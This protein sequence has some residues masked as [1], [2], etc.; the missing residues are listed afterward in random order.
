MEMDLVLSNW[1]IKFRSRTTKITA[2][3]GKNPSN[4]L[5]NKRIVE[6]LLPIDLKLFRLLLQRPFAINLLNKCIGSNFLIDRHLFGLKD[7][8]SDNDYV[9]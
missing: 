6:T 8:R 1:F 4:V 5:A 9:H 7:Y 3:I 2:P